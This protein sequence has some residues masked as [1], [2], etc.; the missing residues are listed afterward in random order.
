MLE[1]LEELAEQAEFQPGR[2]AAICK[3]S[4]RQIERD[5]EKMFQK[6][7]TEWVRELRCRLA[8]TLAAEGY[9][10]KEIAAE[11]KFAS[12]SHFCHEFRKFH[13]VPFRKIAVCRFT[14]G[15]VAI[16]Q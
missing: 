4:L 5:F 7:P 13:G 8:L 16:E 11:L 2:M 10:N 3:V 12:A 9:S 1:K 6:T 14:S 15:E